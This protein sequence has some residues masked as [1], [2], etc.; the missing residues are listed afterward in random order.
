MIYSYLPTLIKALSIAFRVQITRDACNDAQENG[1]GEKIAF[2]GKMEIM[3]I[4]LP[5]IKNVFELC[6][7]LSS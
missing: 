1:L 2:F 6:K 4:S 7:N 5:L 3:V